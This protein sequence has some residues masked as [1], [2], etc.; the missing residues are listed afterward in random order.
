MLLVYDHTSTAGLQ[1]R[2]RQAQQVDLQ[3]SGAIC[4]EQRALE[5]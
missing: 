4:G 5:T 1:E 3:I 2:R